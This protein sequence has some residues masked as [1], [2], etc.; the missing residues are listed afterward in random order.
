[1]PEVSSIEI[2][3][4]FVKSV[5]AT[6]GSQRISN[7]STEHA[8]VLIGEL[9]KHA[10]VSVDIYCHRLSSDVWGT[11]ELKSAV[12]FARDKGTVSFRVVVQDKND[13]EIDAGAFSFMKQ[14]VRCFSDAGLKANFLVVDNKAFRVEPDNNVRKGFAYINNAELSGILV[15][16][17]DSIYQRS[18]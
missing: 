13:D 4:L 6:N 17:F 18:A 11:E 2:Y 16:A 8:V 1:M 15:N 12:L 7:D 9:I 14:S 10:K 3:R 5:I